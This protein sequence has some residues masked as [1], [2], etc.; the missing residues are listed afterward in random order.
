[1]A[2]Q[3]PY[4]AGTTTETADPSAVAADRALSPGR[5]L[6]A[7]AIAFLLGWGYNTF[8]PKF[9]SVPVELLN[10]QPTSPPAEQR[11]L[12]EAEARQRLG[13]GLVHFMSL[14]VALG[15]VPVLAGMGRSAGLTALVGIVSG[16]IGGAAAWFMGARVRE[17]VDGSYAFPLL[18]DVSNKMEGDCLVWGISTFMLSLPV[19]AGLLLLGGKHGTQMASRVPLVGLF[20]GVLMPFLGTA[21]FPLQR[22]DRFPLQHAG[23]LALWLATTVLLWGLVVLAVQRVSKPKG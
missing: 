6:A 9:F 16:L 7:L 11:K 4:V 8:V 23:L 17:M 22:S 20:A 12:A 21:V 5:L 13:N 1:M 3:D 14:G 18:G 19:L 15:L 2:D 10:V